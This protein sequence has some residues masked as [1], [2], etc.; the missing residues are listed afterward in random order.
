[1]ESLQIPSELTDAI[2]HETRIARARASTVD[3]V[4][5]GVSAARYI[6]KDLIEIDRYVL[7]RLDYRRRRV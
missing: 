1:V 3:R 2:R 4:E 6:P 5:K 7:V